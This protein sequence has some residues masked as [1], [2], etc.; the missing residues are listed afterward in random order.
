MDGLVVNLLRDTTHEGLEM[1]DKF[2]NSLWT[3]YDHLH[4]KKI[5]KF[6]DYFLTDNIREEWNGGI[7][8]VYLFPLG[9]DGVENI[10]FDINSECE[11]SPLI[12]LK[13]CNVEYP[14][15]C[16]S[17]FRFEDEI[18]KRIEKSEKPVYSKII[19]EIGDKIN[20]IIYE[21]GKNELDF[22]IFGALG[23]E[24][25]VVLFLGKSMNLFVEVI[26]AMRSMEHNMPNHNLLFK[27]PYS[28][29]GK[30]I[31]NF[32]IPN[33]L[34]LNVSV[35]ISLQNHIIIEE[36]FNDFKKEI[37]KICH[38]NGLADINDKIAYSIVFG[39]HD[40]RIII[41]AFDGL[42]SIYEKDGILNCSADFYKY[43]I[44]NCQS[45]WFKENFNSTHIAIIKNNICNFDFLDKIT[46]NDCCRKNEQEDIIVDFTKFLEDF[47][48]NTEN[49]L[50]SPYLLET[51]KLLSHKYRQYMSSSFSDQWK[52]DLQ[53]QFKAFVDNFK[54]LVNKNSLD[55][56]ANIIID[57]IRDIVLCLNHTYSYI[58]QASQLDFESPIH[59]INYTGSYN[60]ILR[61]YY[62][63]I[64]LLL[65]IGCR[66]PHTQNSQQSEIV[67]SVNFSFTKIVKSEDY[68]VNNNPSGKRFVSF[69]LP[70]EAF[71]NLPK[72]MCYL[73]HEVYHYIAPVNRIERNRSFLKIWLE[74]HLRS[75]INLYLEENL[76]RELT[77]E[78]TELQVEYEPEIINLLQIINNSEVIP[79]YVEEQINSFNN[80]LDNIEGKNI[81]EFTFLF[82]KKEIQNIFFSND[83]S[84]PDIF[85][86]YFNGV[87]IIIYEYILKHHD[88]SNYNEIFQEIVSR[89]NN[90][91]VNDTKQQDI[92]IIKAKIDTNI[93]K[94]LN[95]LPHTSDYKKANILMLSIFYGIDEAVCDIFMIQTLGISSLN[96]Y[97]SFMCNHF[98]ENQISVIK[99][100]DIYVDKDEYF[101]VRFGM[102]V[103]MFFYDYK[104]N[105]NPTIPLYPE[106]WLSDNLLKWAT[107][108]KTKI[109]D[110]NDKIAYFSNS[111]IKYIE[112][113]DIYRE[114]I[115][116]PQIRENLFKYFT[117]LMQQANIDDGKIY[118]WLSDIETFANYYQIYSEIKKDFKNDSFFQLNIDML[119]NFKFQK[120]SA[121]ENIIIETQTPV[122]QLN[123]LENKPD[124]FYT[125]DS[126]EQ[127]INKLGGIQ[128]K[129]KKN[130]NPNPT[131]WF[132]G[133][134]LK[135]HNLNPSLL[136]SIPKNNEYNPAIYQ[137]LY[138]QEFLSRLSHYPHI[139]ENLQTPINL[140]ACMQHYGVPTNLLD[141]TLDPLVA[142]H[143]ALNPDIPPDKIEEPV[144]YIFDPIIFQQAMNI[145]I[146]KESL[147]LNPK[148]IFNEID[149]DLK[150]YFVTKQSDYMGK[151]NYKNK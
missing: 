76:L 64:K 62:G 16:F 69:D 35:D 101:F 50:F 67:F 65:S 18:I 113:C 84:V 14:F 75:A 129:F 8:S 88:I 57:R 93:T 33:N 131:L 117:D 115:I 6:E 27:S 72:Y 28:F 78:N 42:L 30:N 55:L 82:F 66:I 85:K 37:K 38:K 29:L 102:I 90:I 10:K 15:F 60:Q 126:L 63:I 109:I 147:M 44:N 95:T 11:S 127:Y 139:L 49:K 146:G 133:V 107:E 4:I 59:N 52:E 97:L 130:D 138:Q 99:N 100:H 24:D 73:A 91:I 141:F 119:N 17:S 123:T 40:V 120:N 150:D 116:I 125:I 83:E 135:S 96:E 86:S 122:I 34:D 71:T 21:I 26:A 81:L 106:D 128:A 89:L 80:W 94:F 19:T 148:F 22:Q 145:K 104:N 13:N 23:S 31:S 68:L 121:P 7:Q 12:S 98:D 140:L 3:Y 118:N 149:N 103:D 110:I 137:Y 105:F 45:T 144:I 53:N 61:T 39:P 70:Y 20:K 142:L 36:F 132:R 41:P 143:F 136:R 43:K 2:P 112:K 114:K 56:K 111:Y 47:N 54:Y 74:I 5:N 51:F 87:L 48:Q 134:C 108:N 9:I 1:G 79:L 151:E 25:I 92:E 46:C 58:E 124:D 32:T 77:A